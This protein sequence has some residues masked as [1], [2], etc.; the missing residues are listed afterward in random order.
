MIFIL[1][2]IATTTFIAGAAAFFSVYGLAATFSGTFWSV[3]LMGSS[4][5]M[6]KLIAAS[7]LYR[8]WNKTNRWLKT[9][10]MAGVATLMILTSTGIF[11]YLSS[12][13]QQDVL[14]LKQA[15]QQVQVLEE[16]KARLIQRKTQIDEQIA[17][18]P[19]NS[20]K[21]RVQ[22]IKGFKQEQAAVTDRI[23]ELDKVILENKT[24]LI[25]TQAHIGPIT[26]IAGAFGLDTDGATKYLIY[27]I[28]FA[29]D[30]MAVALTLAV[31]IALRLR[32]E[33]IEEAERQSHEERLRKMQNEHEERM[34]AEKYAAEEAAK[35]VAPVAALVVDEHGLP[36]IPDERIPPMPPV[37]EPEE[38]P[39]VTEAELQRAFPDHFA[40]VK[41]PES[42]LPVET[43]EEEPFELHTTEAPLF[44]KVEA[45]VVT[46]EAPETVE[47]ELQPEPD[48]VEEPEVEE[49]A[50]EPE[51]EPLERP[52]DYIQEEE[53]PPFREETVESAE[54][55]VAA[56]EEPVQPAR[57]RVR[58]YG[59]INTVL[60]DAK[61]NELVQHYRWLRDKEK[62][63]EALTQDDRWELGAIE[64]ILRKHGLGLYIG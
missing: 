24:K 51:V 14:P 4:L 46:F 33:E 34:L 49:F 3:V 29:F 60:S 10:L 64:E 17:Q 15:E 21:G 28:I 31:N 54:E 9:Y 63:G 39:E 35:Q 27:L 37:V 50:A 22:L 26:Y 8:Y 62:S 7:Y 44:D 59:S 52:G 6:G 58:P 43:T 56:V 30:P 57:R 48:F 19:T 18:L 25:Q 1:L 38:A 13:Y 11:G 45:D 16:E 47:V 2:L 32:K 20:V 36:E 23:T 12:G 53:V 40:E 42:S 55:P 41:L 61:L 5:E